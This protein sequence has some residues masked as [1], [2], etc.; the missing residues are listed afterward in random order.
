MSPQLGNS[1]SRQ[2][3]ESL[4]EKRQHQ[5]CL[6]AHK[7]LLSPPKSAKN[8]QNMTILGYSNSLQSWFYCK[9]KIIAYF[10]SIDF[11]FQ[12]RS[13]RLFSNHCIY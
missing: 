9:Q 7:D 2:V 11:F 8:E 13:L 1:L 6:F 3:G 4:R 10:K 12:K 5:N